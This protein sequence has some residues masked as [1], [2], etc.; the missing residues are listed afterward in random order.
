[1]TRRWLWPAV[2]LQLLILISMIGRHGYTLATGE[3]VRLQTAPRDPWD[4]FR[5]EHV[6][7]NYEV[8]LLRESEVPFEGR[9]Y[10]SGQRVW[11]LLSKGDRF[12]TAVKVSKERPQAGAGEVAVLATVEYFT[13]QGWERPM[14]VRTPEPAEPRRPEQPPAEP[15]QTGPEVRLRYG[16]EQF[17]VP[18][19]EGRRLEELGTKLEVEAVV[20]RF[21]RIALRKVFAG[22]Q[23]IRWN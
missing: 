14:P 1:M 22:D 10:E 7:L 12:W 21:G 16:I 23:E 8:S 3:T 2:L 6:I 13:E 18:E 17:Y 5:G 15:R 4:P 9:P 11:V 20:D 19:G